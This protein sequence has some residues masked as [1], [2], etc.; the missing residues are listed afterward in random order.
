LGLFC[1][2]TTT[3]A[4]KPAE[5]KPAEAKVEPAKPAE[6]TPAEE[7]PEEAKPL[8]EKPEKSAAPEPRLRFN[9][10]FQRWVDVLQWVARQAD[11]SLVL[12]APPPGTFNYSDARAYTPV[13]AI[14]LLN[15]VLLTKGYTLIRRERMLM[16][17][18]LKDGIPEGF[19][20]RLTMKELNKRGKFELVSVL[21]PLGRR[22]A[23]E[24]NKEITPLLGPHGKS[25][26][27]PKTSQLLITDTAGIMKAIG[28]VIESIPEPPLEPS[29][30]KRPE[31]EPYL[32][33]YAIDSRP[34]V[35][36][37]TMRRSPPSWRSSGEVDRRKQ[38][39]NWK[40]IG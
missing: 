7:K 3:Q 28:T 23:D 38:P 20:P 5:A 4:E 32:E 9:F 15:G 16:L 33:V 31:K 35:G 17:I 30:P 21:F 8:E 40:S 36:Q 39:H 10:R 11:L 6:A 24:V 37:T 34:G 29:R 27:L 1:S 26:S 14:D 12:D 18:N 25:V 22:S 2:A 13:E 19:V